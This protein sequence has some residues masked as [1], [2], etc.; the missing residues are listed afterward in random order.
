MKRKRLLHTPPRLKRLNMH[1]LLTMMPMISQLVKR[2][3]QKMAIIGSF[4][5]RINRRPSPTHNAENQPYNH[6]EAS[7]NKSMTQGSASAFLFINT[8]RMLRVFYRAVFFFGHNQPHG[9]GQHFRL[10]GFFEPRRCTGCF[11][12]LFFFWGV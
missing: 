1:M 10:K 12:F 11:G 7:G 2:P 6:S 8:K 5:N 4:F 3:H 9:L